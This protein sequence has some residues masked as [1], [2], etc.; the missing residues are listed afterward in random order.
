MLVPVNNVK[1]KQELN[2]QTHYSSRQIKATRDSDVV[3]T[4]CV[5]VCVCVC[6]RVCSRRVPVIVSKCV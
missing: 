5:C 6:V 4:M 1:G 3:F 2:D